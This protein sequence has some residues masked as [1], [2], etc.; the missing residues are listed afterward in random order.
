MNPRAFFASF[1]LCGAA[2]VRAQTVQP[3]PHPLSLAQDLAAAPAPDRYRSFELPAVTVVGEK[4]S[5]LREEDRVGTYAQPRWTATRRFPNTRVYVIPEK[6]IEVE[7]W[8]RPTFNRDG[9]TEIRSLY[10]LEIGLPYRFQLDLYYRSDQVG[11][12]D[13]LNGAQFEIRWALA[14]WGKIPLNPTI[15]LEYAPLEDRPDKVEARLLL[16]DELAPRWHY[17]IN[18]NIEAETGGAREIEYQI[19][20][21]LSYTVIDE[22]FSAG[23]E[24]KALFTDD[25]DHR[26]TFTDQYLVGPSFQYRPLPQLTI[27]LA[28]LVGIGDNS[29]DAEVTLNVGYEF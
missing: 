22:K 5:D 9:E 14:D 13:Y 17:G 6:Q 29:P 4:T 26:G 21:G 12:E 24:A 1:V 7:Y 25:H 19:S 15:Y 28:P 8:I 3:A 11:T 18:L 23:I 20:G 27:N 16:G 10:E 2:V